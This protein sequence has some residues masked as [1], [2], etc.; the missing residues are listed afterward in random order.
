M[1]IAEK[2]KRKL[3]AASGGF[4]VKPD[5]HAELF[6]F[7]ENGEL[8]NIEELAHIIG[9]KI[10]GPRGNDEMPLNERDEFENIVLLCP[11]CHRLVDKNPRIFPASM[12]IE[13]KQNHLQSIKSLFTGQKFKTREEIRN[14][15]EPLFSENKLIFNTYGPYSQ[16]AKV[17][18]LSTELMWN[19]LAIQKILPNNR[20]IENTIEINKHLLSGNEYDKFIKFKLHREGFEY[21]KISGDVNA[22]VPTFPENFERIFG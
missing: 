18:P 19:R 4:C 21:N 3:W 14:Y 1:A 5:C 8:S 22:T 13:W 12:I 16:N 7:F 11:T 15:L 9:Q 20:K 2:V 17:D 6:S 10:D